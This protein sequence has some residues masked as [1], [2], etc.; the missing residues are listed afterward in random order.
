MSQRVQTKAVMG[1][2]W[3]EFEVLTSSTGAGLDSRAI[4]RTKDDSMFVDLAIEEYTGISRRAK[5][6]SVRL[7]AEA[8]RRLYEALAVKFGPATA[9]SG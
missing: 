3:T 4:V 5:Y 1:G 9:Q 7:E 8:A 6:T 2:G